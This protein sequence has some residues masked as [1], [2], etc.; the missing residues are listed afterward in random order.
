MN[1]LISYAEALDIIREQ[2]PQIGL[3]TDKLNLEDALG[4]VL[5]QD[6]KSPLANQPFDNS[7]MDGVALKKVDIENVTENNPVSLDL[8]GEIAAGQSGR[9][10]KVGTGQCAE[11]M[12]GAPIPDGADTVI[13]VERL[14]KNGNNIYI[15]LPAEKG[16]NIRRAGEDVSNGEKII[17]IGTR[18]EAKH[19][20]PLSTVGV[21]TL[22]VYKKPLVALIS[23]GS[24]IVS[25]LTATLQPGQ[26]YNSNQPYLKAALPCFGADTIELGTV[27]DRREDYVSRIE[28]AL[29]A[30]VDLI[31]STGA[32]SAGEY[33]FVPQVL[34]DM[35]ADI[36]FH[37][38]AI[39]PGKPIIF[40]KLKKNGPFFLGLPGN[41]VSAAAGLR[42]FGN[43]ILR[44]FQ[45]LPP[46]SPRYAK[47]I[48]SYSKRKAD[49]TFFLKAHC[50]ISDE[51][52]YKVEILPGQESFKVK[53]FVNMTAWAYG[54]SGVEH[55]EN[56]TIIPTYPLYD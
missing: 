40:A 52:E 23:T 17:S 11:I 45:G 8:I 19:I 20:L 38:A 34:A 51:G 29:D 6:V 3:K 43:P 24:E 47:L 13:P 39:R 55:L 36:F 1:S 35:G 54:E 4:C 26:I 28:D 16:A 18:I 22:N 53:P 41:P 56:G 14:K 25:D 2:V 37:K 44:Q 10:L 9:E 32:V 21:S 42:F 30:G 27:M 46:K 50:S 33:D 49:F 12:T 5:A 48:N 31:L 15:T 7:A